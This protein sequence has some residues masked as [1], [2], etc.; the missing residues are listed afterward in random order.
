MGRQQMPGETQRPPDRKHPLTHPQSFLLQEPRGTEERV[1]DSGRPGAGK[2]RVRIQMPGPQRPL[3]LALPRRV[4][5]W[6]AAGPQLGGQR[7]GGHKPNRQLSG[8][9]TFTH[10]TQPGA[11]TLGGPGAGP[12][13][14]QRAGGAREQP[15][16]WV[17]LP[18]PLICPK[19]WGHRMPLRR[20]PLSHHCRRPHGQ[21]GSPGATGRGPQFLRMV[22]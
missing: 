12:P 10:S 8:I 14:A 9:G 19:C 15:F 3:C 21:D 18:R 13:A 5:T 22:S 11:A 7:Q 20:V 17:W 4:S 16:L 2:E 6:E 1:V